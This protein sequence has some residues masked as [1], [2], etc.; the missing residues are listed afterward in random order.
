MRVFYSDQHV[1]ELPAGHRFPMEKYA[2]LRRELV[3]RGILQ[4]HQL[5]PSEPAPLDALVRVH[6]PEYVGRFLRGQLDPR[7]QR[8]IG[9]PWSKALVDRSLA[10]VGGTLAAMRAAC[11]DSGIAGNL[12]GGTH[13]AFRAHGAGYC[14][15]NDLAVTAVAFLDENPGGRVLVV[16]VDVHQGDGTAALFGS[17]PRVFTLSVHGAHNFP[18]QKQPGDLD[19]ELPD[20]TGDAAYLEALESALATAFDRSRP[21][22]VLV[23]GGVD[24]LACDKLGRLGLTQD[25]VRARDQ[26]IMART[27]RLGVP[28]VLT[29]G[30]GYGDPLSASVEAHIG[31]YVAARAVYG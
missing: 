1:V 5:S 9:L 30:G 18:F 2:W 11:A 8:Q 14:V 20:G 10:S 16:D 3:G 27:H 21:D 13:H 12:A 28:V 4:A 24:V 26:A 29:L 19:I 17:D 31:T 7:A 15:F 6:D 22:L 23:Q 25:G